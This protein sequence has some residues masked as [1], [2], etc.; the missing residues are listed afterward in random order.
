MNPLPCESAGPEAKMAEHQQ[1]EASTWSD[2]YTYMLAHLLTEAPHH[3]FSGNHFVMDRLIATMNVDA[4]L[5]AWRDEG[6]RTRPRDMA[7]LDKCLWEGV[8]ERIS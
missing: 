2:T 1:H 8:A 7:A 3:V 6:I 4:P 5:P